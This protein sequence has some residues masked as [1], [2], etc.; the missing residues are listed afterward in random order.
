MSTEEKNMIMR[1][2]TSME[3]LILG[4][5]QVD[6]SCMEAYRDVT[7]R[8]YA[9]LVMMGKADAMI[10]REVADFLQVPVSTATGIIDKL[11]DKGYVIRE[12]SPEDRRI[13]KVKLSEEGKSIYLTLKDKLYFFGK[14]LLQFFSEDE[15]E[16]FVKLLDKASASTSHI[17]MEKV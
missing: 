4:M 17:K 6:A 16:T 3:N 1:F 12:Y 9:L 15:K 7:K 5:Q 8:E 13:I 10:M 2:I 11:I 14:S